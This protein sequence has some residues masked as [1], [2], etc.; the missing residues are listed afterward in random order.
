MNHIFFQICPVL[1]ITSL[2]WSF[3]SDK[4]FEIFFTDE[5]RPAMKWNDMVKVHAPAFNNRMISIVYCF[6]FNAYVSNNSQLT[7]QIGSFRELFEFSNNSWYSCILI[8]KKVSIGVHFSP[9]PIPAPYSNLCEFVTLW[10][11]HI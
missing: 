11:I 7:T 9:Y 3:V 1:P 6:I 8:K 2:H 10:Q 5:K 4:G